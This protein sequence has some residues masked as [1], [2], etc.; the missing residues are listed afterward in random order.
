M[1]KYI[2]EKNTSLNTT[3]QKRPIRYTNRSCH[4]SKTWS[5]G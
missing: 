2:F 3:G 4:K 1:A 5:L